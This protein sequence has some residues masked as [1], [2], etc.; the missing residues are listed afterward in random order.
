MLLDRSMFMTAKDENVIQWRCFVIVMRGQPEF[1]PIHAHVGDRLFV[2]NAL[3]IALDLEIYQGVEDDACFKL[4]GVEPMADGTWYEI[5]PTAVEPQSPQHYQLV[6]NYDGAL[7]G[8][9]PTNIPPTT[10][11]TIHVGTR[12]NVAPIEPPGSA[13]EPSRKG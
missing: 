2:K 10:T 1:S 11:G 9:P 13:G 8:V 6:C 3:G 12:P 7:P 4:L 5:Q